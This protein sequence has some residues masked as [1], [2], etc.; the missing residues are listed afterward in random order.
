MGPDP[1]RPHLL[2]ASALVSLVLQEPGSERLRAY[3]ESHNWFLTTELCAAEALG[4]FK[5]KWRRSEL[6]DDEYLESAYQL[7]AHLAEFGRVKVANTSL[8]D[9]HSFFPSKYF[10]LKHHL[11]LSDA[12][13]IV[14]LT[15]T[16]L[17]AFA[18][19]SKAVLITADR[20]L[21]EAA[22]AEDILVWNILDEAAAP[23]SGG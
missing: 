2:D 19:G 7:R 11:D 12:L 9:R 22:R 5:R 3:F 17:A 10:A 20:G 4:V 21:A 18:N 8:A 23:G 16:A 15:R 13:Q 1:L 6:S 14:T